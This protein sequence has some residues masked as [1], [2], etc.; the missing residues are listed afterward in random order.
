MTEKTDIPTKQ[1]TIMRCL[2]C[3]SCCKETEMLLSN[4]DIERLRRRG[5]DR[6]IFVRFDEKRYALL[7]NQNGNCVF[8]DP[9]KRTCKER[10][11]RPSGCRIYPVMLDEDQGIVIDEICPAKDTISEKQKAKKGKKVLKL[12]EIIDS[13]AERRRSEKSST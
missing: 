13:E 10:A 2:R 6:D 12:L 1:N 3:G 11:N 9:A 8:F 5:Y 7:C 4:E